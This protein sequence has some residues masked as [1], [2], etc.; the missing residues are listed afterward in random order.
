MKLVE[1][2]YIIFFFF[3]QAED[4]IRDVAVTGVQTCALPISRPGTVG[5][6]AAP[7]S[8]GLRAH[9]G[10]EPDT[11]IPH[12]GPV[13]EGPRRYRAPP[14]AP[15]YTRA[16]NR[17]ARARGVA[18]GRPTAG[19]GARPRRG[20]RAARPARRAAQRTARCWG[21]R[22]PGRQRSRGR[23][24]RIPPHSR[25]RLAR[26]AWLAALAPPQAGSGRGCRGAPARESSPPHA[27][28]RRPGRRGRAAPT[29][30]PSGEPPRSAHARARTRWGGRRGIAPSHGRSA[31]A[32]A[33]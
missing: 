13:S 25:P 15:R 7:R 21:A 24:P 16:N 14:V 30:T 4:G 10:S 32:R 33:E 22:E 5:F 23:S 9:R 28:D 19:R 3:F 1:L 31:S 29:S 2:E 18:R 6:R 8:W 27:D 20:R 11:R 26:N 12:R 17:P